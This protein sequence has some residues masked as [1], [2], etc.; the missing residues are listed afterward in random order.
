MKMQF[1]RANVM[2]LACGSILALLS[3]QAAAVTLRT[4]SSQK[5]LG[6]GNST[7]APV[8]MD[9]QMAVM[10]EQCKCRFIGLC[11]CAATIEFMDCVADAC[12]SG[13]CSCKTS[14][15]F[16][17]C[18]SMASVCPNAGLACT[19]EKATC[20]HTDV[21]TNMTTAQITE[22]LHGLQCRRCRL[23]K[24]L[25]AGYMNAKNRLREVEPEIEG[26]FDMLK[27]KGAPAPPRLCCNVTLP[28]EEKKEEEPGCPLPGKDLNV[29]GCPYAF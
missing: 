1:A 6:G 22:A 12:A 7:V 5:F 14:H 21:P 27:L 11:T 9:A 3:P 29:G 18:S 25:K 10:A 26:H 19:Q 13:A 23:R 15:F 2:A 4:Q 16:E 8:Q 24:A 17:S 28:E 20:M